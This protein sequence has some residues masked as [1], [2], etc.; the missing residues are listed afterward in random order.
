MNKLAPTPQKRATL[1]RDAAIARTVVLV[2]GI[3]GCGKTLLSSIVSSLD[4]LELEKYNYPLE[5]A[6]QLNFLGK[7]ELEAAVYMVRM[8]CDLDLYQMMMSRETNF[9][10]SDLS[11]VFSNPRPWRYVKRLFGPGDKAV[12]AKVENEKPI[13]N[14]VTHNLL[15]VG[16]PLFEALGE[17][18]R[19]IEVVRHPLY[20]LKQWRVFMPLYAKDPRNFSPWI[21]FDGQALPWFAKNWEDLYL[22]SNMMDRVIHSIDHLLTLC[23]GVYQ[24]LPE[25]QKKRV[26]LIP[27]EPFVLKT[28]PY[29][30]KLL[31]FIGTTGG[32]ALAK[33]MK[34][35]KVPRGKIADGIDLKI[36]RQYGWRP[37][38]GDEAAELK[39]RR[40]FAAA[41]ATPEAMA[42]LDRLC[43]EYEAKYPV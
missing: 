31:S 32:T 20:T 1:I 4:R 37:A 27:F 25:E 11:G 8:L 9:R 12:L 18:L 29:I 40:D 24:K 38:Q 3:P 19:L 2:N 39:A 5:C 43:R 34:R 42:V 35:Q 30:E 14:L 10:Y 16:E 41:E 36:Y 6:C 17:R 7:M 22:R 23:G 15:S 28:A 13:L 26:M 33:E 21:E